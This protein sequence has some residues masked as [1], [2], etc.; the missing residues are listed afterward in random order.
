MASSL[1]PWSVRAVVL[2]LATL[3]LVAVSDAQTAPNG[4]KPRLSEYQAA[5]G[6][7]YEKPFD[8][9]TFIH[10]WEKS[11]R[12]S[13]NVVLGFL[14]GLFAKHPEQADKLA[15][16]TFQPPTQLAIILSL[17]RADR[18]P[19][20]KRVAERWGW[21]AQQ[22]ASITPVPLLNQIKADHPEVF[23]ALWAASF[24]GAD[25]RYVRPIYDFYVRTA[26]EEGIDAADMTTI[27][28]ARHSGDVGTVRALASKYSQSVFPRVVYA[29]SALWSLESNARQHAFVAA[30]LDGFLKEQPDSKATK[31]LQEYRDR[32]RAM[33]GQ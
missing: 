28:L 26:S 27:A 22:V 25:A 15:A 3:A 21:S 31:A 30:A 8:I 18:V 24:A 33:G 7:Y 5:L 17:Q 32:V 20:A 1:I 19:E 2:A 29:A 4:D 13:E 14:T 23:D 12:R 10:D 6:R 16:G 11:S 9:P